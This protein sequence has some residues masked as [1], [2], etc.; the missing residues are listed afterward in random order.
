LLRGDRETAVPVAASASAEVLEDAERLID[1]CA[2]VI[3]SDYGKGVLTPDVVRRI[4]GLAREHRKPVV[5]DPKGHDYSVYEGA[6]LVTP[7]RKELH[8]ATGLPA[9]T[10][11]EVVAA[12]RALI[13]QA[14]I[15]NVLVTRSQ[16]GMT[17]VTAAG[18]V[19][20][21]PAEA[22]EVFDVSGAGDTVIATVSAAIAAGLPLLD[23]ARLANV[24][25]GIVVGK[26]GTAVATAADLVAALHH[27]EIR[28]GEAKVLSLDGLLEKIEVWRR[29]GCRI[30]F[31]NGCFDLL[32]PGHVSLLAQARAACDRLIVGLNSD[33][34]VQRLKGPSRPVQS[35]AARSTVLAS[36]ADVDAVAIFQEDTPMD[37][38]EAIRPDVLVKGADYTVETVVGADLVQSYGG[39]VVLARLEDGFSTTA[40]IARMFK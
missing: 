21:L 3:L 25:A 16:D 23:A 8:E 7:N 38:I 40:T 12:A 13:E 15:A 11:E 33:S 35:E 4:I 14:G 18:T 24:A 31:T 5:V 20:H 6:A 34:S 29:K 22:R 1:S 39:R 9:E 27:D 17:L 32:H 2:L 26:I 37:L 19:H 10:D 36:L 30:G 28:A